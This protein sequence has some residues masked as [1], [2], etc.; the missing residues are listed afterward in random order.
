VIKDFI[1]FVRSRG[2]IGFAVGFIMG[3][4]I[5]DLVG[6]LVYDILNPVI[7]LLIGT[8]GNLSDLSINIFSASIRYGKFLNLVLNFIIIA[9]VVYL[10]IK[11]FRLEKLDKL[12]EKK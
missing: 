1:N 2:I 4:A 10:G 9:L 3:K 6:S 8:F 12:G 7:G 11:I 5:S